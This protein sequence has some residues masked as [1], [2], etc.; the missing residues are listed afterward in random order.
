MTLRA[1]IIEDE[2][3]AREYLVE[4]LE[5]SKLAEVVGAVG[6][7]DQARQAL[8]ESSRF[9]VDAVFVDV[10]LAGS[11]DASGLGLVRQFA[12]EPN[13]PMFVL[14]TAFKE[15]AIEAFSLD[16]VDYLLK[17][18]TA[19]RVNECLR[20]L[21]ARRPAMHASARARI[22][23]RH[24]KKLVFL[25]PDEVLAFEASERLTFVHTLHGKFDVDLSLSV[26]EL[27]LGRTLM[28]V[29]RNWLVNTAYIKE[30]EREGRDSRIFLGV[31]FGADQ[32]GIR[33]P[34]GRD[35]TQAVR[36]LLLNG[37]TGTR[38]PL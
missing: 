9:T 11:G 15:H 13:A 10:R 36:D 7:V 16:V 3:P 27:S 34:I 29:H 5:E 23:A 33:V 19:E 32:R 20:R 12:Q 38:R 37:A 22:V 35:R 28:R 18:F 30:L 14:A 8:R 21:L 25:E 4:L 17:P 6:N 31:G 24:Q 26:I 1:L 2:L